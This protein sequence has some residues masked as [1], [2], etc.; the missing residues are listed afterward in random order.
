[1]SH[2]ELYF[3]YS[4]DNL[5]HI[6]PLKLVDSF[7]DWFDKSNQIIAALNPLNMYDVAVDG[8]LGHSDTF[9]EIEVNTG[10]G[11]RINLTNQITVDIVGL[12]NAE[13]VDDPD[14]SESS[15]NIY[16]SYDDYFMFEHSEGGDPTALRRIQAPYMLP[17]TIY[18]DHIF[19]GGITF[20]DEFIS[21]TT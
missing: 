20:L 1:M 12:T 13:L 19:A 6:S 16:V 10:P 3:P 14:I 2:S 15:D 7:N 21:A 5:I 4:A 17:G 11:I 18:G 9:S 8:G